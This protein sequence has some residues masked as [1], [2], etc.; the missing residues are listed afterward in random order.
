MT[1]ALA[2][3]GVCAIALLVVFLLLRI[4]RTLRGSPKSLASQDGA[5]ST[6][7]ELAEA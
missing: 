3:V 7:T 6:G 1:L 2:A 5:K 4:A